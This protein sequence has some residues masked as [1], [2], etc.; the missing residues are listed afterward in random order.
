MGRENR[1]ATPGILR[2]SGAMPVV[3][4]CGR[5]GGEGAM[6]CALTDITGSAIGGDFRLTDHTGR[7]RSC[8]TF[9]DERIRRQMSRMVL[10][11]ADMKGS[12][13]VTVS[14]CKAENVRRI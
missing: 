8:F 6:R 2:A 10:L 13:A 9:S 4:A 3:A 12:R 5:E 11:Q 14:W 1:R 7:V